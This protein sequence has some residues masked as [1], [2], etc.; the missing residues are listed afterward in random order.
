MRENRRAAP[1]G[2]PRAAVPTWR[3]ERARDLKAGSENGSRNATL[4]GPL[5]HGIISAQSRKCSGIWNYFAALATFTPRE[6]T[7]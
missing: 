6:L 5:F 2:Q 1:D 4:E 3:L 7:A